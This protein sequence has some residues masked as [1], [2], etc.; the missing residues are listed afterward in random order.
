MTDLMHDLRREVNGLFEKA[1][2]PDRKPFL[3]RAQ[4]DDSLLC[5]DAPRRL[6]DPTCAAQLFHKAGLFILERDGLWFFDARML[7][8]GRLDA[9]LPLAIPPT[10]DKEK[11]LDIWSVCRVLLSHPAEVSNQ[12]LWAVRRTLKAMEAGEANVLS[13]AESLPPLLSELLRKKEPL[14]TL[15]GK[16]LA[17]WL[18][19]KMRE[20]MI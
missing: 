7:D 20:E 6:C 13:L 18:N 9:S 12:P 17:R 16:L 8:Y 3:R 2:L 11:Y 15:A 4:S 14:P 10:P 5:S 1:G 19:Q